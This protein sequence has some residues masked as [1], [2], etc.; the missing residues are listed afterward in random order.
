MNILHVILTLEQGGAQ[1]VVRLL[2]AHADGTHRVVRVVTFVDG[3]MRGRIEAAGVPVDVLGPRRHGVE[4][5]PAFLRENAR[6]RRALLE[7]V[8]THAIDVVQTHLLEMLD[9]VVLSLLGR[10]RLRA[11]LF[12]I[13]NVEFLPAGGTVWAGAKRAA[14]RV[15]YR[16]A[17]RRGSGVVAVSDAV[18]A[19]FVEQVGPVGEK[20]TVIRNGVA[21]PGEDVPSASPAERASIRASL[22][23]GSDAP[24]FL[25]VG[26][27]AEQK[28]H[29][30]LVDA[31][32]LVLR[33]RPDVRFLVAGEGPLA[34]ELAA[35][36]E[37][38]GVAHAFSW[39][40]VRSDVADLLAACDA[41]VLPSLWEGLSI[42][43][44]EAMAA[45]V[46]VVA[47]AV[48]G[49]EEVLTPERTALV[50]PVGD[51][52]ALAG[53]LLRTLS[54]PDAASARAS[55]ARACVRERFG[56]A[57][58]VAAYGALYDRVAGEPTG[59]TPA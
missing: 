33:E 16:W 38:A 51:S 3:P 48:A 2:A 26:R 55:A 19:A 12:T 53:A 46:P 23:L 17:A 41:F 37:A 47:T 10:S 21:V 5:L 20:V 9:F 57:R 58:Q 15:L 8:E 34:A 54:D 29:R 1:E 56:V 52:A 35:R 28:G 7:L 36:A 59:G 27:L 39:L 43:L 30:D 44:L 32:A 25:A 22:G 4:A 18:K 31:A 42:A 45:G 24:A 40:G 49:A 14:H 50:V 13:H 11:V 6:I